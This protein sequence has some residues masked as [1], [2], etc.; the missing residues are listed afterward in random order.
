M[1]FA[2]PKQYLAKLEDKVQHNEKFVQYTFEMEQPHE[3]AFVAGQYVSIKVADSGERRSYSICSSPEI[4]HSFELAVDISPAGLGCTYLEALQFGQEMQILGPMGRFVVEDD[5]AEQEPALV[6][7]ATGSGIAPF[8]SMLLDMLQ[9]R[10]DSRPMVLYWGLRHESELFWEAEF[11]DLSEKF[12]NFSFH[13]VIS[14]PG[15]EWPL[16]VGRV[17]DCLNNHGV[18]QPAGYYLCGSKV[19]IEDTSAQ[20]QQNGI[21]ASSIHFE[22]FY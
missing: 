18:I 17:T 3:L 13:P 19:M 22:K 6:F 8:H 5:L 15:A 20:L 2:P 14:R 12:P 1:Q 11:K 16:C 9:V 4:R 7:I 21:A 10:R